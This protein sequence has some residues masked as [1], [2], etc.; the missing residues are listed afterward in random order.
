M[1]SFDRT[2]NRLYLCLLLGTATAFTSLESGESNEPPR[3]GTQCKLLSREIVTTN[4]TTP[5]VHRLRL[6]LP[7]TAQIP[8]CCNDNNGLLHVR[9]RAPDTPSLTSRLNPYSAHLN[10]TSQTFDLVV[11]IYPAGP[12]P[13]PAV[14]AYLGAVP[15]GAYV[16]VPEIRALDWRRDSER[17]GMVCF[18]VG[19][20]ECLA[21]AGA[22][23]AKGAEVRMVYAVRDGGDGVMEEE[24]RVLLGMFPNRFRLRRCVSRGKE[25]VGVVTTEGEGDRTTYGRVDVRVLEEEFGGEWQ[26][27]GEMQHFMMVGTATMESAVLGMAGQAQLF[28]FSKLRGHPPFLLMKGPYGVNSK[29]E[30]LSPP[31]NPTLNESVVEL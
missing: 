7:P 2:M 25:K 18:G 16:H 31:E 17:T 15:V 4:S 19:V 26:D 24:I 22:L 29:W 3:P 13:G 28:D 27:G 21:P 8:A 5:S 11:K 6:S 1:A 10:L 30:A 12:P 9:V 20:T 23:L 14:S